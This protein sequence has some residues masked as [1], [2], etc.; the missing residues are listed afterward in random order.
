MYGV[1][2]SHMDTLIHTTDWVGIL[3]PDPGTLGNPVG[4]AARPADPIVN[5]FAPAH[6]ATTEYL[7]RWMEMDSARQSVMDQFI[8]SSL[9][10]VVGRIPDATTLQ[11]NLASGTGI[12]PDDVVRAL[13]DVVDHVLPYAQYSVET[14]DD[15][16]LKIEDDEYAVGIPLR[17][18]AALL[19]VGFACEESNR[20]D[21]WFRILYDVDPLKSKRA[22]AYMSVAYYLLRRHTK[23]TAKQARISLRA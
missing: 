6:S 23:A 7:V 21:L 4:G 5:A 22:S 19:V 16:R 20:S 2:P 18:G 9:E 15:V 14:L 3:E 8:E 11:L 1:C 12:Q 10:E 17:I 13:R